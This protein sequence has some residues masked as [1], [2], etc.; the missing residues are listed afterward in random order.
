MNILIVSNIYPFQTGGAETQA[1]LLA[2]A[3]M[4]RGHQITVAGNRI[5][6]T[7]QYLNN[8]QFKCVNIKVTGNN[9]I[10]RAI[11]YTLSLSLFIFSKRGEFNIIYCRFVQDSVIVISFLKKIGLLKVPL[12]SCTE[13]LGEK[14]D[15]TSLKRLPFFWL[16]VSLINK[17]CNCV[18]II[19]SIMKKEMSE[20][21]FSQLKFSYIANGVKIFNIYKKKINKDRKIIF[22]GRICEEKGIPY[23]L[24]AISILKK[25]GI[26]SYLTIAGDGPLMQLIKKLA[27]SLDLT[28]QIFFQ[29]EVPQKHINNLLIENDIFILP[30]LSEGFGI[31]VI[32]AMAAGLPVVVTRC[33]GPEDFVDDS[34]G[35]VVKAGDADALSQALQE[36]IQL[37]DEEL[38]AMGQ[39]ARERIKNNFD[40]DVIA[41]KYIQLFKQ[42]I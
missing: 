25:K 18:N 10:L 42:H 13:G 32:E 30:S 22:I 27:I 28:Q 35:R 37:T 12:I 14:G 31:A 5:P 1:R 21:G 41:D 23:L 15:A 16:I 26:I 3:W 8:R 24:Q 36:L 29:G 34:V 6:S 33:G 17:E 11:S 7:I 38:Q 40:I 9:R 2:E 4:Q 39:A 19:S 20:I